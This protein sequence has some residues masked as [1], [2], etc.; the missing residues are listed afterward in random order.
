M[1]KGFIKLLKFTFSEHINREKQYYPYNRKRTEQFLN[2]NVS[3]KGGNCECDA[4]QL[5][6]TAMTLKVCSTSGVK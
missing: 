6:A 5:E 4:L 1:Q 3:R 2:L